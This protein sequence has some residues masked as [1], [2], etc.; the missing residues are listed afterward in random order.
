MS[1]VGR[2]RSCGPLLVIMYSLARDTDLKTPKGLSCKLHQG[3]DGS[4]RGTLAHG[5]RC[6]EISQISI[7]GFCTC[8]V[9]VARPDP[10]RRARTMKDRINDA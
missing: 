1:S 9:S 8:S 2:W 3:S 5:S 4:S 10:L 7:Q 6:T